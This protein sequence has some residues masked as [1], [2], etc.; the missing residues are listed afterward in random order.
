MHILEPL[1]TKSEKTQVVI[2]SD[3]EESEKISFEEAMKKRR[4]V[5]RPSYEQ[6]LLDISELG[7]VGTGK[8]YEV[9]DNS[10]RKWIKMYEKHGSDF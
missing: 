1:I 10:I 6:L 9:S 5:E 8:K 7:F 3:R 4:K 2:K